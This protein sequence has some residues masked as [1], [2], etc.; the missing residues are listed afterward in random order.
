VDLIQPC[1]LLLA[2]NKHRDL[3]PFHQHFLNRHKIDSVI[4]PIVPYL[5]VALREQL[6]LVGSCP[7]EE[8]IAAACAAR[9]LQLR[10]GQLSPTPAPKPQRKPAQA[11]VLVGGAK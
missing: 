8:D 9:G 10:D 1:L 6:G 3:N 7:S 5:D 2:G 11:Q 4:E